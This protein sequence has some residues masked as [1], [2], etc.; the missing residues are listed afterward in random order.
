MHAQ[1]ER[2]ARG[3]QGRD[4]RV[5]DPRGLDDRHAAVDA[6]HRDM[7]HRIERLDQRGQ[8]ARRQHQRIAAGQDDFPDFLTRTDIGQRGVEFG[9]VQRLAARP[10]FFSAKAEAAIDRTGMQRLQQHAVGIAVDDALHRRARLVADR[11]GELFRRDPGLGGRG[12]K[13]ARD[14]VVWH[15]APVDQRQHFGRQRDRHGLRRRREQRVGQDQPF[16]FEG[17]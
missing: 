12:H 5:V 11:I 7:R 8:A 3:L 4:K 17:F 1:P 14:R 9:V 2:G 13:L 16:A 10:Y 15:I 6:D